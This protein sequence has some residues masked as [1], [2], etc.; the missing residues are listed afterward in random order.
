MRNIGAGKA[1]RQLHAAQAQTLDPLVRHRAKVRWIRVCLCPAYEVRRRIRQCPVELAEIG[2][3]KAL[4][5]ARAL[6]LVQSVNR[7]VLGALEECAEDAQHARDNELA[8]RVMPQAVARR[9][10]DDHIDGN[11]VEADIARAVGPDGAEPKIVVNAAVR[12]S[13]AVRLELAA[14]LKHERLIE[15]WEEERI[16]R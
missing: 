1:K 4:N 2:E 15:G 10:T 11:D 5:L 12:Q 14:L 13:D 9:A 6:G 8:R 3:N 16:S 7:G